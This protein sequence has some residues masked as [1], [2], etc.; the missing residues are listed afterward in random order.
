M[1]NHLNQPHFFF[2]SPAERISSPR[3]ALLPLPLPT[4]N[5]IVMT[6]HPRIT[7]KNRYSS[8]KAA[9]P[10]C[11]VIKGK[12]HTL[13]IPIAHPALTRRNP[14]LDP[15]FSR[16]SITLLIQLPN[17]ILYGQGRFSPCP[18]RD[19][20]GIHLCPSTVPAGFAVLSVKSAK[21]R[22]RG[23]P[24]REILPQA[25]HVL[26]FR[27]NAYASPNFFSIAFRIR[28]TLSSIVCFE[29]SIVTSGSSG[30]S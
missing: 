21:S 10:Y 13:P 18:A 8:T 1:Q 5:S 23:C 20:H 17:L 7:R 4:A 9:P 29:V 3:E 16:C 24:A 30:A 12:R 22:G 19:M 15:K 6:G 2:P 28:S 14:N 25:L 11:P 27:K 26:L